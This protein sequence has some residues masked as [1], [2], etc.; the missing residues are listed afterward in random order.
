MEND[1]KATGAAIRKFVGDNTPTEKGEKELVIRTGEAENILYPDKIR[2]SGVITAPGEFYKKRK[3][4]HDPNKCHVLFDRQKG[5]ITLVV[6]EQ[7]GEQNYEVTGAI[8]KNA[9]LEPFKINTGHTFTVKE[10]MQVL[11]FN[12]AWFTD[13]DDNAKI[14]LALQNF[15][16]KVEKTFEDSNNLRGDAAK[17]NITKL[18]HELQES[19]MLKMPIFKGGEEKTFRVDICVEATDGS[20][21]VWLESR[22][23]REMEV[24]NSNAIVDKELETFSTIVCIEK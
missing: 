6:D 3:D 10:L 5:A 24:T 1:E 18:E 13:K 2:L 11:K 14:V 20:V 23:L 8:S 7:H 17:V 19:F 21:C 4:L 22:D 9:Y 12:R 15:K 16:G